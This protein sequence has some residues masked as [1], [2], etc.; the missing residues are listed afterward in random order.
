MLLCVIN[1]EDKP[2]LLPALSSS[3]LSIVPIVAIVVII[4]VILAL[5]ILFLLDVPAADVLGFLV[6]MLQ[7][8]RWGVVVTYLG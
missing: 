1:Y 6:A 7:G 4:V 8:G 2:P 5:I 3:V